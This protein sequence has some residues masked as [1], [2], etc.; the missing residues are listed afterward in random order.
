MPEEKEEIVQEKAEKGKK[1]KRMTLAEIEK[2][3]DELKSS[4]GGYTS[5]YA[6]HLLRRRDLLRSKKA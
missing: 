5:R 2:K 6:R 1:V 3:L 4:Q